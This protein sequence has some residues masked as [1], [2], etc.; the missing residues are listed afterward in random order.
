MM[1]INIPFKIYFKVSA[2][3]GSWYYSEIP[4]PWVNSRLRCH[5]HSQ[6][7]CRLQNGCQLH[8]HAADTVLTCGWTFIS[9]QIWNEIFIAHAIL[10][11]LIKI[12]YS[13][14]GKWSMYIHISGRHTFCFGEMSSPTVIRCCTWQSGPH[15][16]WLLSRCTCAFV[17]PASLWILCCDILARKTAVGLIFLN[18]CWV[19]FHHSL[20][21]VMPGKPNTPIHLFSNFGARF[22]HQLL[23]FLTRSTWKPAFSHF[24]H[25]QGKTH[26]GLLKLYPT[27]GSCPSSWHVKHLQEISCCF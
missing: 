15:W 22:L 3:C 25:I 27:S 18:N 19:S 2:N 13:S 10:G 1:R 17:P 14:T 24:G 21:L 9:Q 8:T 23:R 20:H 6:G 7:C 16:R 12:E 11:I 26:V 5:V 4:F